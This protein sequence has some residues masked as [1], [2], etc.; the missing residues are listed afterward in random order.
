MLYPEYPSYSNIEKR[1]KSFTPDWNYPSGSR[2]S[3]QMMAEAGFFYMGAGSVCC[4][5]CG[6]KLQNFEP[7]YMIKNFVFINKFIFLFNLVIVHLK[8]MPHFLLYVISYKKFVVLIMS[9][10]LF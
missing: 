2:L 9:I 10:E 5:Y 6:N 3:N 1:I 8:N 4:F 7:R